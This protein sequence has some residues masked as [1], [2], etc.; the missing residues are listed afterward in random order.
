MNRAAALKS[1]NNVQIDAGVESASAHRLIEMMFEGLLTRLA[2][3]K[4]AINQGNMELKG[5]KI[6][7]SISIVLG[8]RDSLDLASGG[9]MAANL[10]DLYDYIQRTLWQ[11][12][13]KNDADLINECG[14]LISQISSAWRKIGK[15]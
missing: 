8:L 5:K 6:T 11:A 14:T 15:S 7:D 9:E 3:A 12:N 4:G 10:D 1:Y 13:L 2:Q